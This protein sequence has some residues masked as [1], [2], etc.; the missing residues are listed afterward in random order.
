MYG[1]TYSSDDI[2][3]A[4]MWLDGLSNDEIDDIKFNTQQQL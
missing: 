1:E 3:L 2:I 4:L